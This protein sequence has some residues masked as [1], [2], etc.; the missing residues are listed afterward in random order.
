MFDIP[1]DYGL[2]MAE[3]EGYIPTHEGKVNAMI[4]DIKSKRACGITYMN[5]DQDYV[6]QFG[7]DIEDLTP[8]D[9]SR[10]EKALVG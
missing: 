7:L 5:L 4:K 3:C 1:L 2:Y 6:S 9:V 10:C 8:Y